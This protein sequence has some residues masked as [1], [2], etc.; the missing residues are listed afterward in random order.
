[1]RFASRRPAAKLRPMNRGFR[2]IVGVAQFG[3]SPFGELQ[4]RRGRCFSAETRLLAYAG[5]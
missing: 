5:L 3:G 1:M 4:A 2:L